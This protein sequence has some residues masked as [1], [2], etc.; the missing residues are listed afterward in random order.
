MKY[1][2][3]SDSDVSVAITDIS[4]LTIN[5]ND[6]GGG[7]QITNQQIPEGILQR[8]PTIVEISQVQGDF[9]R[10]YHYQRTQQQQLQQQ[11]APPQYQ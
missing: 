1:I 8:R 4:Q 3:R 5:Q 7:Q 9:Q 2:K 10:D 11:F 6:I